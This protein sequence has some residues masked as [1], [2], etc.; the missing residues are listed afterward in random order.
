MAR[1]TPS[2][3]GRTA[4]SELSER[5][6][7]EAL[8]LRT[9]NEAERQEAEQNETEYDR[10]IRSAIM[11]AEEEVDEEFKGRR[12]EVDENEQN[13]REERAKKAEEAAKAEEEREAK[14]NAA[15]EADEELVSNSFK[16]SSHPYS[17]YG[18]IDSKWAKAGGA[19]T[20]P[21]ALSPDINI[22][23]EQRN[24]ITQDFIKQAIEKAPK[25]IKTD[26]EQALKAYSLG[27]V[28]EMSGRIK[29][30]IP[31]DFAPYEELG[32]AF[33]NTYARGAFGSKGV[34]D[35]VVDRDNQGGFAVSSP[36]GKSPT[37]EQHEK[38]MKAIDNLDSYLAKVL[39]EAKKSGKTE[40]HP[41]YDP[42]VEL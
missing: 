11:R 4:E 14:E 15:K 12:M 27:Y 22:P 36:K 39:T 34:K 28:T 38:G 20:A 41:N 33:S 7:R 17:E 37:R 18:Y 32:A 25:S 9:K 8:A 29:G 30:G 3:G 42:S 24:Y 23:V 5:L 31:V 21:D 2:S 1:G 16:S 40:R 35:A 19:S 6:R 13:E 26:L 10:A